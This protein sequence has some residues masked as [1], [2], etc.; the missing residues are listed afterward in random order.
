MTDAVFVLRLRY[1]RYLQWEFEKWKYEEHTQVLIYSTNTNLPMRIK[2]DGSID[3]NG[4]YVDT[5]G[6][7]SDKRTCTTSIAPLYLK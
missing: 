5:F 7:S 3:A 1:V 2:Q 6:G 4:D